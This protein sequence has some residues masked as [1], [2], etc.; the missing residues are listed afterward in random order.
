MALHDKERNQRAWNNNNFAPM[1]VKFT[2]V[3]FRKYN[4]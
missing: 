3:Y 1:G 4:Y 2:S